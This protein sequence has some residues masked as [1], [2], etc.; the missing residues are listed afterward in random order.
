[1][2]EIWQ[3]CDPI[4][5]HPP[6]TDTPCPVSGPGSNSGAWSSRQWASQLWGSGTADPRWWSW[7]SPGWGWTLTW[8]ARWGIHGKSLRRRCQPHPGHER[9]TGAPGYASSDRALKQEE[10][11]DFTLIRQ[12][13]R[14]SLPKIYHHKCVRLRERVWQTILLDSVSFFYCRLLHKKQPLDSFLWC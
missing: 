4:Q 12:G 3:A 9:S 14:A 5:S 10:G 2:Y 6:P 13:K 7:R 8:A 1:M 11:R